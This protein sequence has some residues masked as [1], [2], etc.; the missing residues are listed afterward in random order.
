MLDKSMMSSSAASKNLSDEEI[1]RFDAL[2]ESWWDPKGKY[3]TALA[4]NAA[5]VDVML[6]QI[7]AHFGLDD[8]LEQPLSGLTLLDVGCGG[9]LISE[10]MACAGARRDRD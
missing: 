8:A 2:A 4:F 7:G 5:R 9:G 6:R 10:P 3:K 1:A